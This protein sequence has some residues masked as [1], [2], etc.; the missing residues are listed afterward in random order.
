MLKRFVAFVIAGAVLVGFGALFYLNPATA[1]FHLTPTRVYTLPLPLL[2]LVAFLGG[3][4]AVFLLA[5]VR[6]TQWTIADLRRR[7]HEWRR[8]RREAALARGLEL[9]WH[10]FPQRARARLRFAIRS[11][12]LVDA[13]ISHAEASLETDHP[14]QVKALVE[15]ALSRHRDHPRL[16]ELLARVH[17]ALGEDRAATIALERAAAVERESP[18]IL[19]A[20][21]DRYVAEARWAEALH[22]EEVLV[23]VLADA[24][25]VREE[26]PCLRGIRVQAALASDGG[27]GAAPRQLWAL[28][29]DDA[30]FLPAAIPLG[31]R[32][33]N[34]GALKEAARVWTRAARVRPA[35][36]LLERIE[37][38]YRRLGRPNK[39]VLLYRKLG[40]SGAS[41]TLALRLVRF[42]LAEGRIEEAAAELEAEASRLSGLPAF[43]AFRGEIQRLRG[44]PDTALQSF[45][46]ALD[47]ELELR[48][49]YECRACRRALADWV[50]RCPHCGAWDTAESRARGG[51]A[52]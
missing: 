52:G 50:T 31:D 19:A 33:R 40:R 18:R 7:R 23:R 44:D 16:L 17:L 9:R 41:P 25:R 10:G 48:E 35:P 21:R 20:L 30:G 4:L 26:E 27:G 51:D 3:A 13:A 46:K 6:E 22:V 5:I 12:D 36:V 1:D 24:R 45:R 34:E 15:E 32:L 39:V 49:R 11:A 47:P 43:H 42:L 2:L 8:Q 29:A 38:V 14:A 37:E 28:L